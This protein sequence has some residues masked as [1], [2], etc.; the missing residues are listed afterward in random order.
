M[1]Y[2]HTALISIRYHPRMTIWESVIISVKLYIVVF[3]NYGKVF[4]SLCTALSSH[5]CNFW[6]HRAPISSKLKLKVQLTRKNKIS[7]IALAYVVQSAKWG[8]Y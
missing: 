8:S 5:A 4:F 7:L 1:I 2:R 3:G 6:I